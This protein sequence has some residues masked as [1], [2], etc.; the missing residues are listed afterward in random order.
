MALDKSIW[1]ET[2]SQNDLPAFRCPRCGT[3]TL[4]L[5]D[6]TLAKEETAASKAS[7]DHEAWEPD[8]TVE[9]FVVLLRCASG[10]C[11]DIVAVSGEVKYEPSYDE[12]ND[13]SY[14]AV[15]QP[16]SMFPPPPM[17][18]LPAE[19]PESIESE[20]KLAFQFFWAD[21]GACA[22]KIRTSVERLMDHFKVAKVRIVKD[23][24]KPKAPGKLRPLDL[25]TRIDKFISAT[26]NVVHKEH[27][28]ALRVIGN[29]GTHNNVLTRTEMLEAFE[30]YEHALE[31][32]VGKK[33]T[34][35]AKLAKKLSQRR[36]RTKK[37]DKP[38]VV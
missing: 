19:L 16:K 15:L 27:L 11:G 29:L 36:G 22:T 7:Q 20:L 10:N 32:L 34:Q 9:R 17:I 35:I 25:G 21:Y 3:N 18:A 8:W 5:D 6:K 37:K 2:F 33:S 28:H 30:V 1:A 13:W 23:P 26:G 4:K 12:D 31:E 38:F 14:E 24:K